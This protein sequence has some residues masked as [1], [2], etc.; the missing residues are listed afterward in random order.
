MRNLPR[1]D[2]AISSLPLILL[3]AVAVVVSFWLAMAFRF[4]GQIPSA[5]LQY[6]LLA[7]PSVVA[8]FILCNN[9]FNLWMALLGKEKAPELRKEFEA[10]I[11]P[12]VYLVPAMVVAINQAQTNGC[13]YMYL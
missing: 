13:T 3:D 2:L 9:A 1:R 12:G 10:N 5:Y 8:V 7:M 4:D 6:L 11:L